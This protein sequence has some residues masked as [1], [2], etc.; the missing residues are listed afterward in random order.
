M[1]ELTNKELVLCFKSVIKPISI[2][3]ASEKDLCKTVTQSLR[4]NGFLDKMSADVRKEILEILTNE[5][6]NHQL[7]PELSA[8]NFV[9]NELI[10]EYLE[11]NGFNKTS[12]VLSLESGQ[13]KQRVSRSE[14]ENTMNI[15]SGENSAKIPLL[16][17]I[18]S[19]VRK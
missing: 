10:K 11:W 5:R 16:Y 12:D 8:E 7:S 6:K 4:E 15:Q 1:L 19:S 13:P 14:L 2:K 18:I 9:I 17:S 3:M